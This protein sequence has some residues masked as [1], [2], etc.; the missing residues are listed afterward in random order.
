MIHLSAI[1]VSVKAITDS[2]D[3]GHEFELSHCRILLFIVIKRTSLVVGFDRLECRLIPNTVEISSMYVS[4][5]LYNIE[6]GVKLHF[7]VFGIKK[8]T[9]L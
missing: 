8:C 2:Y 9:L 7:N 5:P 3:M 1:Y 6:R 4:K